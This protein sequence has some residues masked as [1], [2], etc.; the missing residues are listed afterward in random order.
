MSNTPSPGWVER[1]LLFYQARLSGLKTAP[2]CRFDPVCSEYA[3]Q[4]V[5]KYGAVV[6][7]GKAL[8]RLLKCG[9]WHPGG[10]DPV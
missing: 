6:G 2:T 9:P 5:R 7:L 10:Y 8:V 1:A 4:A 3:V